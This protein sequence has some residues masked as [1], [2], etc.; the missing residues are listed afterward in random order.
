[1]TPSADARSSWRYLG[2]LALSLACTGI[3][4][5]LHPPLSLTNVALL[6]VLGAAIAGLRL[7]RA[8]AALTAL[9]NVALFNFCFVPPRF[10]FAVADGQYLVTFVAMLAVALVIAQLVEAVRARARAA[11]EEARRTALLYA[12][13]RALLAERDPAALAAAACR[14]VEEVFGAPALLWLP[15]AAGRLQAGGAAPEL[16]EAVQAVFDD[17]APAA[18][19]EALHAAGDWLCLP[20]RAASRRLGV[21][22]LRSGA[23]GGRPEGERHALLE[24]FGAQIALALERAQFAAAA[25]AARLA[26][27]TEKLRSTL[28]ASISHDVRTPL[29]VITSASSTLADPT[30]TLDA[31]ARAALV[32]TIEVRARDVAGLVTNVLELMRLESGPLP[33]QRD[34]EDL[35]DLT[36]AALA[37]VQERLAGHAVELALPADLPPVRVDAGLVTQLLANLLEN[38][39]RHTPDGTRICVRAEPQP[40]VVWVHVDDEGPGLPPGPPEALFAKF[41][42]GRTEAAA[43]GAGLGLA[44]CRAIVEAHGGRISATN[45][46]PR[47][48]RI[49]FTLP[50]EAGT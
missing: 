38:A 26:S 36:G 25:E 23:A 17:T 20:L 41:H 2:G 47:G 3:G 50:C 29:A 32:H 49:S 43:G 22:A 8:A 19:G 7:G 13:S 42:R 31:A 33:L 24:A 16:L 18:P 34:W 15:D 11:A 30:I 6:Y 46:V 35:A 45:R 10:S 12:L 37:R 44:I 4:F 5:L 48:A 28:L 39:A 21:L 14:Q 1:M 40:G 9:L 27:E